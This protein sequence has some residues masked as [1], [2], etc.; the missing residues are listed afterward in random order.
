VQSY[1]SE[2]LTFSVRKM[3][4]LRM[5]THLWDGP[6]HHSMK[7]QNVQQ[8]AATKFKSENLPVNAII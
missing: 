5:T 7:D 1:V 6:V 3:K 4:L 2:L 8:L